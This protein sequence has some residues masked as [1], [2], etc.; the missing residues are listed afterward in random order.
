MPVLEKLISQV[1]GNFSSCFKIVSGYGKIKN[2]GT[3]HFQV[4]LI[5]ENVQK[6]SIFEFFLKNVNFGNNFNYLNDHY[7]RN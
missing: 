3:T 4:G 2:L 6:L 1:T 5:Y 7:S